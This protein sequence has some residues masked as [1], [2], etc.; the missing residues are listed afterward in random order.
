MVKSPLL[1]GCDLAK[2]T[3]E[4]LAI[5]KNKGLIA[6]N[7]DPLGIQAVKVNASA[8]KESLNVPPDVLKRV[9]AIQQLPVQMQ[10]LHPRESS[11]LA[12]CDWDPSHISTPQLIRVD[13]KTNR[14]FQG[15]LCLTILNADSGVVGFQQCASSAESGKKTGSDSQWWDVG[16][17][18][19]TLSKVMAKSGKCLATDGS[20]LFL[21]DCLEEDPKCIEHRCYYSI[22][23]RQRWYMSRMSGQFISS[24]TNHSIP[25]VAKALELHDFGHGSVAD[26][27]FNVPLCLATAPA[28]MPKPPRLPPQIDA[29]FTLQVWAGPLSKREFAVAL[30]NADSTGSEPITAHWP[31]I[32][33]SPGVKMMAY[34]LYAGKTLGEYTDSITATVASHD[35]SAILLS[36]VKEI[37]FQS[38]V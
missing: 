19:S 36:P 8:G 4:S 23:Q 26:N 15:D 28:G 10:A 17:I 38:F 30:I 16:N 5:L 27:L 18:R 2:I 31:D 7:Q 22:L 35:V 3:N 29:S 11:G 24:F 37:E 32:G 34:D 33:I 14:I 12:W 25:P 13:S 20:I 9:D 6:V 1:I 21:E